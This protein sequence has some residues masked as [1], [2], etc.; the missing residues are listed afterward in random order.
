MV[1]GRLLPKT[2]TSPAGRVLRPEDV[3]AALDRLAVL[4][5][6]VAKLIKLVGEQEDVKSPDYW[7]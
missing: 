6:E 2:W 1:I 7:G 3:D 5:M 4:E